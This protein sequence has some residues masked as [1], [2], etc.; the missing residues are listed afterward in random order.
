[1]AYVKQVGKTGKAWTVAIIILVLAWNIRC[2]YKV[3]VQLNKV[4]QAS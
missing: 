3:A 2:C 1:M 4:L